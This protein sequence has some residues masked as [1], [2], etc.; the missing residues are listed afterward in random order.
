MVKLVKLVKRAAAGQQAVVVSGSMQRKAVQH[1]AEMRKATGKITDERHAAIQ[2]ALRSAIPLEKKVTG[3]HIGNPDQ[4]DSQGCF[5]RGFPGMFLREITMRLYATALSVILHKGRKDINCTEFTDVVIG[6]GLPVSH[7]TP[8]VFREFWR[9]TH[10]EQIAGLVTLAPEP[11]DAEI[12]ECEGGCGFESTDLD[13]V[14]RHEAASALCRQHAPKAVQ[15]QPTAAAAWPVAQTASRTVSNSDWA[16]IWTAL[17][18]HGWSLE[19]EGAINHFM[20]PGVRRGELGPD[21]P[22]S[23]VDYFDSRTQVV[24]HLAA[25]GVGSLAVAA[26]KTAAAPAPVAAAAPMA[27]GARSW[28]EEEDAFLVQWVIANGARDWNTCASELKTG[29]S[30][31]A[32]GQHYR[33]DLRPT[34]GHKEGTGKQHSKPVGKVVSPDKSKAKP[35]RP[36]AVAAA[37]ASPEEDDRREEVEEEQEEEQEAEDEEEDEQEEEAAAA[38]GAAP[39]ASRGGGASGRTLTKAQVAATVGS[40]L[41]WNEFQREAVAAGFANKNKLLAEAWRFYKGKQTAAATTKA[42]PLAAAAAS[43]G[44]SG[45]RKR[46]P[47]SPVDAPP[48]KRAAAAATGVSPPGT[49]AAQRTGGRFTSPAGRPAQPAASKRAAPADTVVPNRRS[50]TPAGVPAGGRRGRAR[51]PVVRNGMVDITQPGISLVSALRAI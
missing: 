45:R 23:R 7:Y 3:E 16:P 38:V 19:R 29:R 10:P 47:A 40:G 12:Y 31:S 9:G 51:N 33:T 49:A 22:R 18:E 30:G 36:R 4:T 8:Q 17:E 2:E 21:R 6:S 41:S 14:E 5:R 43:A 50:A 37:S 20:P 28:P 15:K 26:Q 11:V 1:I 35:G 46:G 39:R 32:C 44:G 34:H 13:A 24:A 48:P 27:V 42:A 25:T